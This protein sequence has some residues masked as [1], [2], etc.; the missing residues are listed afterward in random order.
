[1]KRTLHIV[2]IKFCGLLRSWRLSGDK[3]VVDMSTELGLLPGD[4]NA[5]ISFV[6]SR[7]HHSC[8]WGMWNASWL[9]G[10]G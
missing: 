3:V 2:A 9:P 5:R 1:M 10:L 8:L 6:S 7:A 4:L